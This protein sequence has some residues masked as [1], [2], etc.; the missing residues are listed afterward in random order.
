MRKSQE[1]TTT[2]NVVGVLKL[3]ISNFA[4]TYKLYDFK[5]KVTQSL[6][7]VIILIIKYCANMKN[8][9][10]LLFSHPVKFF[11]QIFMDLLVRTA[12]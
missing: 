3:Q 10:I 2:V 8:I 11:K 5:I 7:Y 4:S 9:L 1:R 12:Q 6:A